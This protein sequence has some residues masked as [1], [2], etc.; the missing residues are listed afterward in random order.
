M[1]GCPVHSDDSADETRSSSP[2]LQ[3]DWIFLGLAIGMLTLVLFVAVLA[4]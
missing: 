1:S 2:S 3:W 4:P